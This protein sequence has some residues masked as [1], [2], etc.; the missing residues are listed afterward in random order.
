M[1]RNSCWRR[2]AGDRIEGAE[3]LVHQH[4]GRVRRER[5]READPL[6]LSARELGRIAGAV[7]DRGEVD[8]VE[9][10]VDPPVDAVPV[11]PEQL[12]DGRD[13]L[14]N[15]HV[16][17]Q[18]RLLDHV[19]DP[20]PQLGDVTVSDAHVADPDVPVRHVDQAVHH[21]HRRG[22]ATARRP[23]EDADVPRRDRQR[24]VVHGGS[25]PTRVALRHV[26]EDDASGGVGHLSSLRC[27]ASAVA[28]RGACERGSDDGAGGEEHDRPARRKVGVVRDGQ[29]GEHRRRARSRSR[30]R[31][32]SAGSTRRAARR[33]PAA[34]S[35]PRS[36][37]C[38]RCASRSRPSA[39]R[40]RRPTAF[41][42]ATGAPATRAPSSSSDDGD[43][44]RDRARRCG[45]RAPPSASTA[46]A[47]R[48]G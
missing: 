16:G 13:V 48:P 47:G 40:A 38:R 45:E 19:A 6:A 37:G 15:G 10:L 17:E 8:E 25:R 39:R 23:D 26:V 33:S 30:G 34:P 11:P 27:D 43:E 1:R 20:A 4:H 21:L 46:T 35:A 22:L 24:E 41:S 36:G 31:A 14:R 12:R 42:S 29:P 28:A 7:V 9:Q 2:V 3:R 18:P 5:A 44:R 32:S